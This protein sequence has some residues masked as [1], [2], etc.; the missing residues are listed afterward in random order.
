[1]ANMKFTMTTIV[2]SRLKISFGLDNFPE[3]GPLKVI[4]YHV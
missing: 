3:N 4:K 1:M 2:F